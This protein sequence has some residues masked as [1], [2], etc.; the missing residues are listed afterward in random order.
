[1]KKAIVTGASSGI[2]AAISQ[3]LLE[4][5]YEVFGIG[6]NFDRA[7]IDAKEKERGKEKEHRGREGSFHA[8]ALDLLD[9]EELI[10]TIREIDANHDIS[11]LVNSAGVGY[12]GL[13][14][15]LNVGKIKQM[16]RT[17]LEV[18]MI[19]CNLL[20]RDLKKNK[21]II[22]NISS[23]TAD[24]KNPHGCAYGA[25]KAGLSNFSQS[26]F[27]ENRKYGVRVVE[28]CPD[29]TDTNLYRNASFHASPDDDARL[30]PAEVA[31]TV[32]FVLSQRDGIAVTKLSV[33]PQ[34][35]R[36]EKI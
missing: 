29:M 7:P 10:Q 19:L 31:K 4:E 35:H 21:G 26:L 5:G 17:N 24:D 25:T 3:M 2:G 15:E 12:Y 23:V 14:E 1:M 34:M 13:H 11:L 20:M 33:R 36:I 6:R 22:I 32:R 28:I 27:M 16:V 30:L 9:T 8:I 18:P